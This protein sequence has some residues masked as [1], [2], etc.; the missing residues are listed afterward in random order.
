MG[1]LALWKGF[2]YMSAGS[3]RMTEAVSQ[4]NVQEEHPATVV[5]RKQW[6]APY[7]CSMRMELRA[8]GEGYSY[9]EEHLLN[10]KP[11]QVDMLAKVTGEMNWVLD[12]I[13]EGFRRHNIIEFKSPDDDLNLD[14]FYKNIGYGCLYKAQGQTVNAVIREEVTLTFIREG[15]PEKLFRELRKTYEI[16]QRAPGI[17]ELRGDIVKNLLFPVQVL[18]LREMDWRKHIWVTALK[19]HITAEHARRLLLEMK[20]IQNAAEWEWADSVLQL[21][22]A[23]NEEIFEELK[24]DRDMC[25]AFRELMAKE[26]DEELYKAECRGEERGEQRGEVQGARRLGG[27][28]KRMLGGESEESVRASGVDEK[29]LEM[30]L[31]VLQR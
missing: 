27:I 6:H 12:E 26:I 25:Q 16:V 24:G 13:T 29:L 14:V 7:Y 21:A 3:N 15:R 11:L 20:K 8:N 9:E 23:N 5:E 18:V 1:V 10:T 2:F 4:E 31:G 22:V 19:R 17:Y 28:I 30:A